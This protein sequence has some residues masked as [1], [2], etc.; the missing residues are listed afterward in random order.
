MVISVRIIS[1]I[2][3]LCAFQFSPGKAQI[4]NI[5]RFR[6]DKDTSNLWL[7]NAG[8]G[9]SLKK[10]LNNV[11]TFNGNVN[12]VYLSEKHSYMTINFIKFIRQEAT[13][14]LSEG[15]A[16]GRIS[17]FRRQRLSYEPFVQIQYDRGRG[18]I[19]RELYGYTFRLAIAT[20]QNTTFAGNTGAM[21]EHEI[22]Q[23]KVIRYPLDG[24]TNRAEAFFIKSTSNL[25]F[26]TNLTKSISLFL[27]GYYQARFERFFEPRIIADIQLQLKVSRLV[28]LNTQFTSTYDALPL[29]EG[30]NFVYSLN[31]SLVINFNPD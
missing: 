15:Y 18:L 12:A 13:N 20:K 6:L 22:W 9:F 2:S 21:Y 17:F 24:T 7:G 27:V 14:L 31:N 23:G 11:Y 5:E 16:H 26:R 30:N 1:L 4:L 10:Q 3:I 8:L 29:I 25:S 28:A 19:W